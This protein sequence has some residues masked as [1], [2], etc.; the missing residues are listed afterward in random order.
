[1]A[2]S[3]DP[4]TWS[5]KDLYDVKDDPND[6]LSGYEIE[7]FGLKDYRATG[8]LVKIAAYSAHSP[9]VAAPNTETYHVVLIAQKHHMALQ[10]LRALSAEGYAPN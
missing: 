10:V 7:G 6:E 5:D 8:P 2:N 3:A 4:T 1:M 9:K